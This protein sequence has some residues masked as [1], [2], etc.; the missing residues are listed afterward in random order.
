M[1]ITAIVAT[2]VI[3]AIC[4]FLAG[5]LLHGGGLGLVPNIVVGVIGAALFSVVFGSLHLVD[6]PWVNEIVGGTI[7]SVV[8]L[9]V[10]GLVKKNALA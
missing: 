5:N 9:L 6:M 4:G 1:D 3:G 8:L 7:G 2:V 10:V